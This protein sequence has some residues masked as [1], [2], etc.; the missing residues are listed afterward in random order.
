[1]DERDDRSEGEATGAANRAQRP[2][3]PARSSSQDDD[4]T[5]LQEFVESAATAYF[6]T[7][8]RLARAINRLKE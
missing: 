5:P 7:C 4:L 3:S 1:M 6:R 8:R 2:G